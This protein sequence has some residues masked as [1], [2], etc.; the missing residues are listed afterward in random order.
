M[1]PEE[2]KIM[3][4][5][6]RSKIKRLQDEERGHPYIQ[7]SSRERELL[8]EFKSI[9][10][11]TSQEIEEASCILTVVTDR[12]SHPEITLLLPEDRMV[13]P[14]GDGLKFVNIGDTIKDYPDGR[15]EIIKKKDNK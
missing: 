12:R 11:K 5:W 13:V 3:E 15:R 14:V 8:G 10:N 4:R 2:L 6:L 9:A 1:N 7:L